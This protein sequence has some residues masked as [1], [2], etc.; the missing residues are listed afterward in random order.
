MQVSEAAGE[1]VAVVSLRCSRARDAVGKICR[2]LEP[3]R[4]GVV[5]ASIAAAGDTIVHTMFVEVN[6]RAVELSSPNN[7]S[8][9]AMPHVRTQIGHMHRFPFSVCHVLGG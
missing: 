1:K 5:T 3:L 7:C 8:I 9:V 2:A 6:V 4:L